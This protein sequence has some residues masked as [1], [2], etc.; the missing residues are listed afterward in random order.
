MGKGKAI[1][2]GHLPG[3]VD[4]VDSYLRLW[5][6]DRVSTAARAPASTSCGDL[7]DAQASVTYPTHLMS[8]LQPSHM[9]KMVVFSAVS[10]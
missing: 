1:S 7:V 5:G 3:F 8:K 6:M 10:M 9:A 4:Q 2:S